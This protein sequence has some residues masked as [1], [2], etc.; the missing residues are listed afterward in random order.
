[1]LEEPAP[2]RTMH[3]FLATPGG[4]ELAGLYPRLPGG[5]VRRRVLDLIRAMAGED[6]DDLAG[7]A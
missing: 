3:D 6:R 4:L 2:E 5:P 1:M 7:K